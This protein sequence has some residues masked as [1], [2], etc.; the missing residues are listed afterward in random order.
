MTQ[1]K[2]CLSFAGRQPQAYMWRPK[3]LFPLRVSLY[4]L[5]PGI[6]KYKIELA[7]IGCEFRQRLAGT[8]RFP[9]AIAIRY[10]QC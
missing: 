10:S 4:S 7:R 5:W 2:L 8:G 6:C 9:A 3:A 1:V